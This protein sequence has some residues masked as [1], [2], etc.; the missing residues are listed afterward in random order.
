MY[1]VIRPNQNIRFNEQ[2]SSILS[3]LPIFPPLF[4][5]SSIN[6]LTESGESLLHYTLHGSAIILKVGNGYK[7][8]SAASE[9]FL[10]A[11]MEPFRFSV[12]L[13]HTL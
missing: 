11:T 4:N 10:T 7:F 1:S 3:P 2:P 6:L 5:P 13:L 8:A 9:K 12:A